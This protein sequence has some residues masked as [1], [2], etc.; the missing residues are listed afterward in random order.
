M[1]GNIAAYVRARLS[2]LAK[3]RQ[4]PF[5]ELLQYYGMERFLYRFSQSQHKEDFLLKGALMLRVWGAPGS[6]PTRDIDLLGYVDNE[7]E[8]LEALVREVCV[9]DVEKDGMR[10]D[11]ESVI[12]ER[13][14]EDADYEGV[15]I[16]F[17]GFLGKARIPMQIDVGFGDVVHPASDQTDYP[18]ILNLPAPR[19]RVYPRETTVAEK[20]QAMVYL[21]TVNSRMKDFFDIWLLARQFDFDGAELARAIGKTFAARSTEHDPNPVAL[22]AAFT[23]AENTQKQWAAFVRRPRRSGNARGASRPASAIPRAGR[24]GAR[25]R[26]RL[27]RPLGC[28][29]TLGSKALAAPIM[30]LMASLRLS[31]ADSANRAGVALGGAAGDEVAPGAGMPSLLNRCSLDRELSLEGSGVHGLPERELSQELAPIAS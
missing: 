28:T 22:T 21:G 2:N 7:I 8:T 25:G 6:R 3:E 20:F 12:G 4:R 24:N 17:T 11:A 5:Q 27:R 13:I 23:T 19:L 31:L 16:K 1:S 14:T 15:R 29:G 10:F 18:T 26:Q 30:V 9:L